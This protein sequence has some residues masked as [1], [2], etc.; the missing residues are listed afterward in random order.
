M[1]IYKCKIT[2]IKVNTCYC[3][4]TAISLTSLTGK[5][6]F[7]Q[8][9]IMHVSNATPFKSTLF[10]THTFIAKSPETQTQSYL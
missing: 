6:V 10:Y 4:I 5:K 3:N 2:E 7:M 9:K 8:N 1:Y